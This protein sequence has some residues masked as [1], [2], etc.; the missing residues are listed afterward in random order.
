MESIHT[1]AFASLAKL[2]TLDISYNRLTTIEVCSP[3]DRMPQ[4]GEMVWAVQAGT[5]NPLQALMWLDLSYNRIG[6]F[7]EGAFPAR[8]IPN[9]ILTGNPLDCS[10][11][12]VTPLLTFLA[13]FNTRTSLP[14]K[15]PL[16]C[17]GQAILPSPLLNPP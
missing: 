2:T 10:R 17:T 14:D 1:N 15:P 8:R 5:L 4:G 6:S 12:A 3:R 9:F 7:P 16:T 11:N 13:K